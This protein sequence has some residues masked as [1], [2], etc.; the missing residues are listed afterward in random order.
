MAFKKVTHRESKNSNYNQFEMLRRKLRPR[1]ARPKVKGNGKLKLSPSSLF[2]QRSILAGVD[3]LGARISQRSRI[4]S[5]QLEKNRVGNAGQPCIDCLTFK[6]L[7][8]KRRFRG[9]K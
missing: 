7:L 6:A 1:E 3:S 5:L 8:F 4:Q 2:L 9:Q